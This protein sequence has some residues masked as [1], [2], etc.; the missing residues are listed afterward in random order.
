MTIRVGVAGL[1]LAGHVLHIDPLGKIDGF[2]VQ[3]VCDVDKGAM[4]RAVQKVGATGFEDFRAMIDQKDIDLVVVATPNYLHTEQ[5]IQALEA[6]KN[7]VVDKPMALTASDAGRMIE[8]AKRAGKLLSVYNN[9]RWDADYMMVSR[10]WQGGILG[11]VFSVESRMGGFGPTR[12]WRAK[13]AFGGGLLNDIGPH[14]IDQMLRLVAS[15]ATSVYGWVGTRIWDEEVDN[16]F[17]LWMWHSDGTESLIEET[18]CTKIPPHRWLIY[19]ETGSL[20]A[21]GNTWTKITVKANV[22]GVEATLNPDPDKATWEKYYQNVGEAIRGEAELIVKPEHGMEALVVMD[23]V[24][25][26]AA[27]GKVVVLGHGGA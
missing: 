10:I 13:K 6:G 26:S 19:G 2:K 9:R 12:A 21:D 5:A 4:E 17:K 14:I 25:E 7:V 8:A 20:V 1:G 24:R 18:S 16:H 23:A 11:K 22:Q 15:P 3:A 27:T